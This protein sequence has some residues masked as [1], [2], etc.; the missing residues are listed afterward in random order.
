MKKFIFVLVALILLLAM[1]G[2]S[3]AQVS[4]VAKAGDVFQSAK[5]ALDTLVEVKDAGNVDNLVLRINTFDK[6]LDLSINEAK[7]Y[8]AKLVAVDK[9]SDYD[10]WVSFALESLGKS[11]D[12]YNTQKAILSSTTLS[13]EDIK[14]IAL[15]FKNWREKNYLP[16]LNQIQ[17]FFLIKDEVKALNIAEKRLSNI[18]SDLD[19]IK[20]KT[21]DKKNVDNYLSKASE[22]ISEA[23]LLNEKAYQQ[24]LEIYVNILQATSSTSTE[25][26][27]EFKTLNLDLATT[28]VRSTTSSADE[29]NSSS[30]YSIKDL[31][32]TSLAKVKSAYQNFIE[33]S[34]YVR[35]LL[36]R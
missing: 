10:I 26:L 36:F 3:F 9:N 31:V 2:V 7:E 15:D 35:K 6:V 13:L 8:V 20:L 24:F 21:K 25:S 4:P 17:E 16:I 29:V 34:N 27:T 11:I 19:K 5:E 30:Q 33:I 22:D 12:Y 23:R 1:K 32:S 18:K 14:K 28:V